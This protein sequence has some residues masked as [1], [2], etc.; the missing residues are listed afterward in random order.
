MDFEANWEGAEV[1]P[2]SIDFAIVSHDRETETKNAIWSVTSLA[3]A[4]FP[5]SSILILDN[6][7][8]KPFSLNT[9]T[10]PEVKFFRS[11]KNLGCPGGRNF[12]MDQSCAD[13]VFHLDDDA[14]VDVEKFNGEAIDKFIEFLSRE[15]PAIVASN[16][17]RDGGVVVRKERP[18]RAEFRQRKMPQRAPNFVGAGFMLNR[19]DFTQ[20]GSFPDKFRYGGEESY[21]ALRAHSLGHSLYY[22]PDLVVTHR[23]SSR[24]RLATNEMTLGLAANK[25]A[26]AKASLGYP[27]R[28]TVVAYALAGVA[29]KTRSLSIVR[30]ALREKNARRSRS[31]LGTRIKVYNLRKLWRAKSRAWF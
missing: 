30:S 28:A 7:S 11:E 8:P 14:V 2:L 21:L 19:V 23:P 29:L 12:L 10:H 22:Y 17:V 26:S 1:K 13:Y 25:I 4:G 3:T 9:D 6:A 15:K 5:I 16:I 24:A 18:F 27:M 31:E 20:M